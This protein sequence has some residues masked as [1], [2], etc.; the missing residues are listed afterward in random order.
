MLHV[1]LGTAFSPVDARG[2]LASDA[3]AGNHALA[4]AWHGTQLGIPVTCFMPTV[5]PL[6]K[7]SQSIH[8]PSMIK[9]MSWIHFR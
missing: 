3:C 4:L 5:A 8:M 2:V 9:P 6:T 7:V 1:P